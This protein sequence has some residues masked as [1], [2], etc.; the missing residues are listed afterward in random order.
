[1]GTLHRT[2]CCPNK[3]I[4]GHTCIVTGSQASVLR[5]FLTIFHC[6]CFNRRY[7]RIS[8]VNSLL[9]AKRYFDLDVAER[10][11]RLVAEYGVRN[12]K[13]WGRKLQDRIRTSSSRTVNDCI[14]FLR[15]NDILAKDSPREVRR[16]QKVCFHL[17]TTGAQILKYGI[18][19][20]FLED[21][22]L[23]NV[24]PKGKR[25]GKNAQ[26][27]NAIRMVKRIHNYGTLSR[28]SAKTESKGQGPMDNPE[29]EQ[30]QQKRW[31]AIHF[32]LTR[33]AYGVGYNIPVGP[34]VPSAKGMFQSI[35]GVRYRSEHHE[36]VSITDLV[37]QRDDNFMYV[38]A[39]I[40]VTK[41]EAERIMQI[42]LVE[43]IMEEISQRGNISMDAN[44]QSEVVRYGIKDKS[45]A[46]YVLRWGSFQNAVLSMMLYIYDSIRGAMRGI[47]PIEREV[48]WLRDAV[49]PRIAERWLASSSVRRDKTFVG[50]VD[51]S[52]QDINKLDDATQKLIHKRRRR[53]LQDEDVRIKR[54]FREIRDDPELKKVEKNFPV[55]TRIIKR[56]VYPKFLQELLY[57]R[58]RRR[59]I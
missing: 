37:E 3:A 55:I 42:L 30:Q 46:E 16:G 19:R 7:D 8:F 23:P 38:D 14:F 2:S 51:P 15:D 48:R 17:T 21:T 4:Y 34:E 10:I 44:G 53:Y 45:L 36:G 57:R 24:P 27:D 20:P 32:F 12:K 22:V 5:L 39:H 40:R 56:S 31:K 33:G 29:Q 25:R 35:D 41:S 50:H 58:R 18:V 9:E 11:V 6:Q 52:L 1:L 47:H 28:A 26:V 43:G 13:I 54:T 49:G 59:K